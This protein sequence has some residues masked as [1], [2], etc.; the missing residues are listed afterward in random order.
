MVVIHVE[1]GVERTERAMIVAVMVSKVVTCI[2]ASVRL[3]DFPIPPHIKRH[4]P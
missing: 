4:P 1:I 2:L 3:A